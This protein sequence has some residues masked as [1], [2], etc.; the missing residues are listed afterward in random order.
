M[1]EIYFLPYFTSSFSLI[2]VHSARQK[3]RPSLVQSL[4]CLRFGTKIPSNNFEKSIQQEESGRKQQVCK[5]PG[6]SGCCSHGCS[7]A[8]RPP[9][10]DALQSRHHSNPLRAT[11]PCSRSQVEPPDF[12]GARK[13]PLGAS[14]ILTI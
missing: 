10:L 3:K 14:T 2:T 13:V 7:C 9:G 8:N 11:S 4:Q 1:I 5:S 6:A 12:P